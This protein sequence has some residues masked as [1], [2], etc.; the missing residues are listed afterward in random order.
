MFL[1]EQPPFCNSSCTGCYIFSSESFANKIKKT[2]K[3]ILSELKEL[4]K[5]GYSIIPITS[6]IL[7]NKNYIAII[8]ELGLDYILTNGKIIVEKPNILKELKNIGIKQIRITGNFL[9][10][11]QNLTNPKFFKKAIT[12]INKSGLSALVWLRITKQNLQKIP[13]MVKKSIKLGVNAIQFIRYI[14]I[15]GERADQVINDKDTKYFFSILKK[16]REKYPNTYLS[17]GGSFGFRYRA[18]KYICNAGKT[19]FLIG[20]DNY[21]YP[22]FYLTQKENRLGRFRAGKLEIN[23][24]FTIKGSKYDCLAYLYNRQNEVVK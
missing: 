20:L 22:C 7:L 5:Q 18:K 8:K 19:K 15:N 9:N 23:K 10:S 2:E 12:L 14:P 3:Q 21:I 17:A 24:Q 13:E 16:L 4:K 11:G 1:P 6:E